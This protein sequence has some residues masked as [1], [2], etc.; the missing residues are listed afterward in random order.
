MVTIDSL[1]GSDEQSELFRQF[2]RIVGPYQVDNEIN[3]RVTYYCCTAAG[4]DVSTC[5]KTRRV[6]VVVAYR[7]GA[8]PQ[9]GEFRGALPRN[10][11]FRSS[12]EEVR[13]QLGD[14]AEA[15]GEGLRLPGPDYTLSA[16][17]DRE[18]LLCR[19]TLFT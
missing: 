11:S 7:A 15:D 10:L 8:A 2:L 6:T 18:G 13:R 19:V 3:D 4:L 14:S 16:K 12:V 1:I 5:V 17:F 9:Y